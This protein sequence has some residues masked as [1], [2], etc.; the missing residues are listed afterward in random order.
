M[1]ASVERARIARGTLDAEK[2]A[3]SAEF[4]KLRQLRWDLEREEADLAQLR[5]DEL[6][7]SAMRLLD[8]SDSVPDKPR[9]SSKIAR[10]EESV[11]A[12]RAAIMLQEKRATQRQSALDARPYTAAA[13]DVATEAQGDAVE[14]IKTTLAALAAPLAQLVASARVREALVGER[15]ALTPG[16]PLPLNGPVIARRIIDGIPDRFRTDALNLLDIEQV[17]AGISEDIIIQI[18]GFIQ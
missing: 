3:I 8:G 17:A 15:F 5:E 9:R 4:Q 18:E 16:T 2:S 14:Q 7:D 13:L 1:S 11:P 6:A 10:L 12:L